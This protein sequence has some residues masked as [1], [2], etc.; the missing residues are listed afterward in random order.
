VGLTAFILVSKLNLKMTLETKEHGKE[1]K[2]LLS[3]LR[4]NTF[5][6]PP[7]PLA[8]HWHVSSFL[9]LWAEEPVS[10]TCGLA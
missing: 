4:P 3:S 1:K 5:S 6:L 2:T 10:F 8:Q 9:W 7:I